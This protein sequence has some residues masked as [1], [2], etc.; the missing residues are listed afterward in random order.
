MHTTIPSI[1]EL[2]ERSSVGRLGG[3]QQH[4]ESTLHGNICPI[5][6]MSYPE[7]RA[8][9]GLGKSRFSYLQ[10]ALSDNL[11]RCK[12]PEER[13]HDRARMLYGSIENTP[14]QSLLVT[15]TVNADMTYV[16]FTPSHAVKML[17]DID[18]EMTLGELDNHLKQGLVEFFDMFGF[19][20]SE[21]R[22]RR[23][24]RELEGRIE[25]WRHHA[26]SHALLV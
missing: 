3:T 12:L 23:I 7:I 20:I 24:A 26:A 13:V 1:Q 22:A 2:F 16:F 6:L 21:N 18:D 5:L 17:C 14:I 19:G 4:L 15:S 9:P 8:I 25:P 11:L 10:I